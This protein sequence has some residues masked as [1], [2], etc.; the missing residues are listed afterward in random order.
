MTRR[1]WEWTNNC[2][3]EQVMDVAPGGWKGE[4][5]SKWNGHV[6]KLASTRNTSTRTLISMDFPMNLRCR[7]EQAEHSLTRPRQAICYFTR[8]SLFLVAPF[9]FENKC[10]RAERRKVHFYRGKPVFRARSSVVR[11]REM[12][13]HALTF[14]RALKGNYTITKFSPFFFIAA[15]LCLF[16]F[17]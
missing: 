1:R 8:F 4:R 15:F 7:R 17:L 12:Q 2:L 14:M 11:F 10:L 13:A 3:S 6:C 9:C 16:D 5:D